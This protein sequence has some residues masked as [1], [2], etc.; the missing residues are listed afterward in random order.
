MNL[1]NKHIYTNHYKSIN[2]SSTI[3]Y[4]GFAQYNPLD[5]QVI[6]HNN[7]W[8]TIPVILEGEMIIYEK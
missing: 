8:Y 2:S 7:A 6:T 5:Y 3:W 4:T 1:K